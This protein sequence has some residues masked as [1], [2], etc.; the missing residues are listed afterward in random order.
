M[1]VFF[2]IYV[3]GMIGAVIGPLPY[4]I[5]ECMVR[6]AEMIAGYERL[7]QL[8]D[9]TIPRMMFTCEEHKTAPIPG[10]LL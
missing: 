7:F 4:P 9:P 8:D 6:R 5:E 2:V 1:S 10:E 3:H